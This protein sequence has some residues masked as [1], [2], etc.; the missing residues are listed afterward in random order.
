MKKVLFDMCFREETFKATG[1][2]KSIFGIDEK[3]SLC[4]KIKELVIG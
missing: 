2:A 1:T 3:S 4:K